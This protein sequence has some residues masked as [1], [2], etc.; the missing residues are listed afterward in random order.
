MIVLT[1]ADFLIYFEEQ[2]CIFNFLMF[3]NLTIYFDLFLF[4]TDKDANP[5]KG[6]VMIFV[7]LLTGS[8]EIKFY[9]KEGHYSVGSQYDI[10][11]TH[12]RY[13]CIIKG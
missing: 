9:N 1:K 8:T 10:I 13:K 5:K 3:L 11:A 12:P 7:V 6:N 4:H 2:N